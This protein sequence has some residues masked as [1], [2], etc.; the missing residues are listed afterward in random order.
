MK[1]RL[2]YQIGLFFILIPFALPGQVAS[3]PGTVQI[4]DHLFLDEHEIT[5]LDWKEY[6]SWVEKR[7][8]GKTSP[9]Y[10]QALPDTS[11]WE[12]E[13]LRKT[14]F[15]HPA[16]NHYPVVGISREQAEAYC[17]WR[18]RRVKEVFDLKNQEKP[19]K[20]FSGEFRYRLPRSVEWELIARRGF[21]REALRKKLEKND[22][23]RVSEAFNVRKMGPVPGQ[24]SHSGPGPS[25]DRSFFP[26]TFGIYGMVGNVA[27]MVAEP[28]IAKGGSWCHPWEET[29]L[30]KDYLYEKPQPWLG[31]RCIC[32]ILD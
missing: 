1:I 22:F 18:T 23:N 6:L 27:E 4:T 10:L 25:P 15:Q 30:S 28:G 12:E 31:F 32:E 24:Q 9:A 17:K 19:G 21:D 14:Y 20:A 16:Y 8:E 26:N 5:N 13:A 7:G 11:V 3:F 2:I 29:I